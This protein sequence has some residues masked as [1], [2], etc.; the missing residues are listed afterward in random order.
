MRR[1][2]LCLLAIAAP[3]CNWVFGIDKTLQ[4]DAAPPTESVLPPARLSWLVAVTDSQGVPAV[5]H[6]YRGITPAPSVK[7]GRIGQPLT[8]VGIDDTGGFR[9]PEDYEASTWRLVYELADGIPREIHWTTVLD[10]MPH[11]IVPLH[12]RLERDPIPG[13]NTMLTMTPSNGQPANHVNPIVFTTGVWTQSTTTF[14][15]PAGPTFNHNLNQS[16]PLSGEPGGPDAAKG[17]LVVLVDHLTAGTC[18]VSSGSAAFT[19]GLGDGPSTTITAEPWANSGKMTTVT[20]PASDKV[21]VGLAAST[22][23]GSVTT[24]VQLG[25]TPSATMPAFTQRGPQRVPQLGLRGPL[26]LPM[27]DC[28]DPTLGASPL[29]TYNLPDA[30]SVF[31]QLAHIQLTADRTVPGGPTLTHG[32][33]AVRPITAGRADFI[34]DVA[35]PVPP[36]M[37]GS[38]DL[39]TIDGAPFTAGPDPLVLTF[40][41]EAATGAFTSY[42]EL[43]LHR[44]TGTST[45]IE[46]IY[47]IMDPTLMLDRSVFTAGSSYAFEIRAFNGA[48]D[49]RMADF[50]RYLPTQASAVVWTHTFV[51]Q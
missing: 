33:A 2:A 42:Y 21:R 3:A 16:I 32:L 30:L 19:L 36:F 38:L 5:A 18:R 13:P 40:G 41:A 27:L 50:T 20:A 8:D 28:T 34:V 22:G 9:I 4:V 12:G 31:P 15:F 25:P 29:P 37:L 26:L 45:V 48:P 46:H 17:D 51:V 14:G 43:V 49:V 44:I 39:S 7:I 1:V 24:V 10:Q 6:E 11:A 23:T 35:M 47:T